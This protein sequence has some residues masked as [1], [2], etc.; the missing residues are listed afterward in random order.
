MS[1]VPADGSG[2]FLYHSIGMFPDKGTVIG[3]AL[4]DFSTA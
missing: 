2:Y 1:D 3:R 4:A